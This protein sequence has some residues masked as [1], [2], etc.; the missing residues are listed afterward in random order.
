MASTTTTTTTKP[1]HHASFPD[2]FFETVQPT[3]SSIMV[4]AFADL[5]QIAR[6]ETSE[7][8]LGS[9]CMQLLDLPMSGTEMVR[10]CNRYEEAF[11]T[12]VK[13]N[14]YNTVEYLI[15]DFLE[16][17][18]REITSIES[19][20]IE[21]FGDDNALN[22][23]VHAIF[24]NSHTKQITLTF[25]GSITMQDWITDAKLISGDIPNPLYDNKSSDDHQPKFLGVHLG[26]RDYLYDMRDPLLPRIPISLSTLQSNMQ[27]G[28]SKANRVIGDT[29]PKNESPSSKTVPASQPNDGDM[30]ETMPNSKIPLCESTNASK[31]ND[32]DDD[33]MV[34]KD[35]S[36]S[37]QHFAEYKSNPKKNKIDVILDQVEKML[38][39]NPGYKLYITG[40]SLGGALALLASL[41]A[42]ARFATPEI[43]VTCVTIANPRVG[44]DRFRVAIQTL[45][46]EKKLRCLTV[47]NGMDL[48]P[49][50]PNRMC[51]GDWCNPNKFCF[52]GMQLILKE[53]NFTIKYHSEAKDTKAE[54]LGAEMKRILIVFCCWIGMAKQHNYREY[55]D[56]LVA[57]KDT[58][59]KLSLNDLYEKQ[60]IDFN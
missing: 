35:M 10:I 21:H 17:P 60:G 34:P 42:A 55:L 44:D 22:E 15:K 49:S 6:D 8:V 32:G 31:P 19:V 28:I 11:K 48:V 14:E 54:E 37:N 36:P 26:F 16:G 33:I 24:T 59:S 51:R 58:L 45:E 52:V 38:V 41:E 29:L 27:K 5:R 53:H 40:H 2:L 13:Y 43:P 9:G 25:R 4:F 20:S 39:A 57:Q 7:D 3:I 23:C 1:V 18:G 12:K 47:H 56:R 30:S 46:K 50:M